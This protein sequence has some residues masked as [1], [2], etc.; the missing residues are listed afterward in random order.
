MTLG[1]KIKALRKEKKWTQADLAGEEITR[2][3]L[4]LIESDDALPSLPTLQYLAKR[5][6]MPAG[7]FLDDEIPEEVYRKAHLFPAIK[8]QFLSGNCKE[9]VRLAERD[10]LTFDDETAFLLTHAYLQC[11]IDALHRGMMGSAERF[12]EKAAATAEKSAY[13][14]ETV[15]ARITL[16][17]AVLHNIQAPKYEAAGCGYKEA[18][19]LHTD[20]DFFRYVAEETE[21]YTFHDPILAAHADAKKLI[22]AGRYADALRAMEAIEEQRTDRHFSL[23]VLFRLYG[24]IEQCH[25]SLGD[26]A[27]AYRYSSKRMSL[28]SAFRG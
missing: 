23:F 2:N 16:L 28:L 6:G 7:Y 27:S 25:K 21:G 5:L 11:A 22:A 19:S 20:E 14:L 15:K 26:F 4:S 12:C 1:Q 24:D 18:V 13:P 17:L 3:M 10:L 8:K 9:T